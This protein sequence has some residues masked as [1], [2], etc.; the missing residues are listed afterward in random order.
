ML[1]VLIGP[2][3]PTILNLHLRTA[4]EAKE[5]RRTDLEEFYNPV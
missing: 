1:F 3:K 5:R 4:K 2:S